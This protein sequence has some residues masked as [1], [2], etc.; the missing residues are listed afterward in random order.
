VGKQPWVE[1]YRSFDPSGSEETGE[2]SPLALKG[3]RISAGA[4]GNKNLPH[5]RLPEELINV[6]PTNPEEIDIIPIIPEYFLNSW[7]ARYDASNS[8]QCRGNGDGVTPGMERDRQGRTWKETS[9]PCGAG[10]PSYDLYLA[11]RGKSKDERQKLKSQ[12][13]ST[14][15]KPVNVCT[16]LEVR[17]LF[18]VVGT[19]GKLYGPCD[20]RSHSI[21]FLNDAA[22][23]VK[24]LLQM[25]AAGRIDL[26]RSVLTLHKKKERV[27][28]ANGPSRENFTVGLKV[29]NLSVVGL[30]TLEP[31]IE[32]IFEVVTPEQAKPKPVAKIQQPVPP[33]LQQRYADQILLLLEG[34]YGSSS[35]WDERLQM[36]LS[37]WLE[38]KTG[39]EAPH[40]DLEGMKMQ[41]LTMTIEQASNLHE[42]LKNSVTKTA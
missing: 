26:W 1:F 11:Q 7:F 41:L 21:Y 42:Q 5:F 24:M 25:E 22:A 20:L 28:L 8:M 38:D 2:V 37:K 13:D 4:E 30:S 14:Y 39:V 6:L 9:H 23:Q 12:Y 40:K 19:D 35:Q 16:G 3:P 27:G 32:P 33:S 10:C 18:L 17:L 29:K 36:K 31:K 34:K 15:K